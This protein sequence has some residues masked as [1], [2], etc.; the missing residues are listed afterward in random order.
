MWFVMVVVKLIEQKKGLHIEMSV[1]VCRSVMYFLSSYLNPP[2][3]CLSSNLSSIHLAFVEN[4]N[5]LEYVLVCA[6]V[7]VESGQVIESSCLAQWLH[8]AKQ[9][10][11]A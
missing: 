10:E 6:S 1:S 4:I 3:V 8:G 9:S 5:I 7:H 11:P 2:P